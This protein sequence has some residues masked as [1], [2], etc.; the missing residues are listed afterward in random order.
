VA[1]VLS[2]KEFRTIPIVDGENLVGMV[3]TKDIIRYFVENA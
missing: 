2:Q 3:S 1:E